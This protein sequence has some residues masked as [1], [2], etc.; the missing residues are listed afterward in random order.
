MV[1]V[2]QALL[3]SINLL[4]TDNKPRKYVLLSAF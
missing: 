2:L 4:D 1:T 3:S